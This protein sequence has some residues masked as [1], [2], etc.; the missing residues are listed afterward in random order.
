[1][2]PTGRRRL[3]LHPLTPEEALANLIQVKPE[4]KK[5]SQKPQ[6]ALKGLKKKP[7]RKR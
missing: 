7:R 5:S 3:S 6:A 1:M 2:A 4:G